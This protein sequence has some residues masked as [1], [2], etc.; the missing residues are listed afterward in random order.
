MPGGTGSAKCAGTRGRMLAQQ[1]GAA[2]GCDQV[3]W[4]DSVD[5]R[6]VEEMGG[7]NLFF[8]SS[9]NRL[10][11]PMLTGTLLPGVTRDSILTLG[12]DLGLGV[13]NASSALTSGNR[14]WRTAPCWKCSHAVLPQ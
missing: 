1:Q 4:L 14:A 12:Q 9:G 5:H 11:T 6:D 7:V 2:Q 13:K 10:V 8:V 3:V